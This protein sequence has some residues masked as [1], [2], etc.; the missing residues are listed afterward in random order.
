MKQLIY[1]PTAQKDIYPQ[2]T[3]RIMS[4]LRKNGYSVSRKDVVLTWR[5]HSDQYCAEWLELPNDDNEL[6][7]IIL[8]NMEIKN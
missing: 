3:D 1:K 6:M 4:V 5:D 2:D 8:H 7:K